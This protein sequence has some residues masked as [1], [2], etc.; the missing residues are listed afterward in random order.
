MKQ[1]GA[2]WEN[3]EQTAGKEPS[4]SINNRQ[5]QEGQL[6]LWVPLPRDCQHSTNLQPKTLSSQS[7]D[8]NAPSFLQYDT[9]SWV[10][11]VAVWLK[12][13]LHK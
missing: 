12:T 7:L 6:K 2:Q 3:W 5:A 11:M 9:S 8:D 1:W 4:V 13:V 10:L